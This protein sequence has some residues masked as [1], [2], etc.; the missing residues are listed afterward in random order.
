MTKIY[1]SDSAL[2]EDN[3]LVLKMDKGERY[4]AAV[5]PA[6]SGISKEQLDAFNRIAERKLSDP[7]STEL[8]ECDDSV[9]EDWRGWAKRRRW[10]Q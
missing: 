3:V 2:G 6:E 10:D 4:Y 5:F 9:P 7:L 1:H 8:G